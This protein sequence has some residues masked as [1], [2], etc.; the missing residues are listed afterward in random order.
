MTQTPRPPRIKSGRPLLAPNISFGARP[1]AVSSRPPTTGNYI[2]FSGTTTDRKTKCLDAPLLQHGLLE[3]VRTIVI[4]R[5][6]PKRS[7]HSIWKLPHGHSC[8]PKG[9]MDWDARR[10]LRSI[11][12]TRKDLW[13]VAD[14]KIA[15]AE[16][17]S[18]VGHKPA[19][20]VGAL[21]ID[22]RLYEIEAKSGFEDVKKAVMAELG[23]YTRLG[24]PLIF[25]AVGD[26]PNNSV[27][28]RIVKWLVESDQVPWVGVEPK[29]CPG[30]DLLLLGDKVKC[31]LIA[32]TWLRQGSAPAPVWN[33]VSDEAL[34]Q[35]GVELVILDEGTTAEERVSI[36]NATHTIMRG[37]GDTWVNAEPV[38]DA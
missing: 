19:I 10:R 14:F 3:Y 34:S 29:I 38:G 35:A 30:S 31:F 20:Y 17:E 37:L 2:L 32:R 15:V 4:P 27:G 13:G 7:A 24:C 25:D 12:P 18:A 22:G 11:M 28:V 16:Y 8:S 5:A 36:L 26:L 33:A 1:G 9:A 23:M 6:V 21:D